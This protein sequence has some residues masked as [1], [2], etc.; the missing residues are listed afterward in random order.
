MLTIWQNIWNY[1]YKILIL[2]KFIFFSRYYNSR[3]FMPAGLMFILSVG[4]FAKLLAKNVTASPL[5][6]KSN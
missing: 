6:V 4:M 3:K 2:N 1:W 5:Q